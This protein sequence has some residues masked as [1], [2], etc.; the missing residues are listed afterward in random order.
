M[1]KVATVLIAGSDQFYVLNGD[2][3]YLQGTSITSNNEK[4]PKELELFYIIQNNI[5]F[6]SLPMDV[7]GLQYDDEVFIINVKV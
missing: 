2:F 1:R 3:R 4:E 5:R 7:L 6:D